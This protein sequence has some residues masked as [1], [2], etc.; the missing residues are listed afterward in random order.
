MTRC[1]VIEVPNLADA[2]GIPCPKTASKQCSDCGIEICECHV[3]TCEMC[4]DVFCPSCMHFHQREHPKPAK[5]DN[6]QR[7]KRKT[8]SQINPRIESFDNVLESAWE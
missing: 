1:E 5:A 8:G 4:R 3:E 7:L 6:G 2:N